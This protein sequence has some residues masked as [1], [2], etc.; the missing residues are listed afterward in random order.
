MYGK[1]EMCMDKLVTVNNGKAMADSRMIATRFGKN[2]RDVLR[3]VDDKINLFTERNFTLSEYTDNSG[4]KNKYYLLD[5]DFT[6]YLIMSFTGKEADEWKLKYIEAF[7]K[8]EEKL[9]E[10]TPQTYIEALECLLASEKAK[11]KAL[12]EK[13]QLQIELDQNKEWYSIKRVAGIHGVSWKSFNWR[14][15][16][17]KS[18]EMGYEVVKIFDANYGEVNT[19]HV[20]VWEQ[21][22]PEYEL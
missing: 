5:R 18:K 13:K 9:K 2:H 4:K 8:M 6:T 3:K 7:N 17:A 1:G 21:C 22:Y 12:E 11:Q 16:K 19:Y 15:L 20:D 14:I 10:Q